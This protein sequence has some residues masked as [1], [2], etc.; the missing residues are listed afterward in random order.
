ME[1]TFHLAFI[2]FNPNSSIPTQTF[3]EIKLRVKINKNGHSRVHLLS[4]KKATMKSNLFM[5]VE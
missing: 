1:V 4:V 3:L 5:N 2:Y